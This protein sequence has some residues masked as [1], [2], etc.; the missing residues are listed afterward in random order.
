[1]KNPKF[2][3]LATAFI[4]FTLLGVGV[5]LQVVEQMRPCPWCVIQ[6][7]AFT[8]VGL[9]CLIN[10]CLPKSDHRFGAG[11]ALVSALTG[12]GAAGWHLWIKAHP[13]ISCGLDPVETALKKVFIA[14]LLPFLFFADGEC[15]TPYP[16]I[17]GL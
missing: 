13:T 2:I 6:R 4:C 12:A 15:A 1:M 11:L 8:V 3:L 9:I 10:T 5:Y 16:P 17:L 14:K 7:Y